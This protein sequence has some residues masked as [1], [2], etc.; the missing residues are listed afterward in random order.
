MRVLY[1]CTDRQWYGVSR[2]PYRFNQLGIDQA[3]LCPRESFVSK[4]RYIDKVY[5]LRDNGQ[6]WRGL[7]RT[8]F[9]LERAIIDFGVT[10]VIPGDDRAVSIISYLLR[11]LDG[12]T[13]FSL[14]MFDVLK[15]SVG[16]Y[17]VITNSKLELLQYCNNV[18]IPKTFTGK[19]D[20]ILEAIEGNNQYPIV[21][22]KPIANGGNGV[23]ICQNRE[24]VIKTLK[25][26]LYA[27]PSWI[28]KFIRGVIG[29]DSNWLPDNETLIVQEYVKGKKV[30]YTGVA[31]AGILL[32]GFQS[33]EVENNES[34]HAVKIRYL[35]TV[36]AYEE[37]LDTVREILRE[38]SFTG[39]FDMDFIIEEYRGKALLLE[40]NPRITPLH[41]LEGCLALEY[42][43]LLDPNYSITSDAQKNI[44]KY[45]FNI[46]EGEIILFP[47]YLS[48]HPEEIDNMCLTEVPYH[49]M[50]LVYSYLK[51]IYG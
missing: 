39:F 37:V 17:T 12:H 38:L 1:F 15:A 45:H 8:F 50:R 16:D 26:P 18:S 47:Q 22:K 13:V 25:N 48:S 34:G 10:H 43:K 30:I 4:S 40:L 29:R 44:N 31:K 36:H 9:E 11:E 14:T 21:I 33:E 41:Y 6:S 32:D 28:K 51:H 49:D 35:H 42:I 19:P 7:I 27:K 3:V 20:D 46:Y 2:L 23:S 24:D 5:T